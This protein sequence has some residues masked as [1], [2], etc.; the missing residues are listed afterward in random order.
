MDRRE[1]LKILGVG[2]ATTALAGCNAGH[3]Q[4]GGFGELGPVP[5]D[6][7]TYRSFPALGEDKVSLV[8]KSKTGYHVIF[9]RCD[10]RPLRDK[11]TADD[12]KADE[13]TCIY[14]MA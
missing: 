2:T 7:M 1:F 8:L 14:I 11:Y 3:E 4:T 10:Y 9:K 12:I 5:T 6:K 13:N